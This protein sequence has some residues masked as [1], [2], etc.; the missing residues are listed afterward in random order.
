[1][2]DLKVSRKVKV[3]LLVDLRLQE[4]VKTGFR[5]DFGGPT[6][7][8]PGGIVAWQPQIQAEALEE[9]LKEHLPKGPHED[10]LWYVHSAKLAVAP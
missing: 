3:L 5:E 6:L 8:G 4:G 2:T 1:M 7:E 10:E 9:I